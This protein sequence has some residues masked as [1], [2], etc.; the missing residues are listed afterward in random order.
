[1]AIKPYTVFFN[2][3]PTGM[4]PVVYKEKEIETYAAAK[5]NNS[6]AAVPTESKNLL[7]SKPQTCVFV[8]VEAESTKEALEAVGIYFNTGVN[9][10][11]TGAVKTVNEGIPQGLGGG[12]FVTDKGL[13][14]VSTELKEESVY[15]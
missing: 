15:P 13:A 8:T 14:C 2:V 11:S 9:R 4:A 3:E 7:T 6:L 12:G 10:T 1:M 5:K